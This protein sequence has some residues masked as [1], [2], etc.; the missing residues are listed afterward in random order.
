[1]Y[2][3]IGSIWSAGVRLGTGNIIFILFYV[4]FFVC[5]LLY[6]FFVFVENHIE[7]EGRASMI[8]VFVLCVIVFV[9]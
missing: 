2:N 5:F 1:M 4:A 7:S 8:L 6:S 3:H 9:S